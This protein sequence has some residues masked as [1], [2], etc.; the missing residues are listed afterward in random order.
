MRWLAQQLWFYAAVYAFI[1]LAF[2]GV[3]TPMSGQFYHSTIAFEPETKRFEKSVEDKLTRD[4]KRNISPKS[5]K[6]AVIGPWNINQVWIYDIGLRGEWVVARVYLYGISAYAKR[7]TA[8]LD[9]RISAEGSV[10]TP[11]FKPTLDEKG[12]FKITTGHPI[13]YVR[14]AEITVLDVHT[15]GAPGLPIEPSEIF[16][17]RSYP[18]GFSTL[19]IEAE[20]DL[21]RDI[22][23]LVHLLSGQP[24]PGAGAFWRMLYFSVSTITTL[25][26]GDIVPVT[27]SAR[28]LVTFEAFLGPLLLGFFLA[29]IGSKFAP[30]IRSSSGAEPA[31]EIDSSSTQKEHLPKAAQK[32][33][34]E[35]KSAGDCDAHPAATNPP[36][37]TKPSHVRHNRNVA[38]SISP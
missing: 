38:G 18:D 15:D 31:S 27:P 24:D 22:Q 19:C 10:N 2:A 23:S 25:G 37:S 17:C 33:G 7:F 11:I 5:P 9:L 29:V 4:I 1:I 34:Q 12:Q 26:F 6:T 35:T 14:K 13:Y 3:F 8:T 36:P 20:E 16:P 30:T 32:K 21:D 28:G